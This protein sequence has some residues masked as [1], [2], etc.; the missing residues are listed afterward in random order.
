MQIVDARKE[1]RRIEPE[2]VDISTPEKT[3]L[4]Y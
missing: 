3:L 1:E 2:R 4:A